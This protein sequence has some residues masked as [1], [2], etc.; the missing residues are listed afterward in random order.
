MDGVD[1]LIQ[2]SQLHCVGPVDCFVHIAFVL[3]LIFERP[4]LL[5]EGTLRFDHN[6]SRGMKFSATWVVI[7]L[8]A[9]EACDE[10]II[11][12]KKMGDH[13]VDPVD[14]LKYLLE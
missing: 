13:D 12:D 7:T 9:N 3:T 11:L 1:R 5:M 6:P 10:L 4:I 2:F 14:D 8:V